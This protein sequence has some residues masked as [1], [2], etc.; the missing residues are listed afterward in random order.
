MRYTADLGLLQP[1]TNV[2]HAVWVDDEDL[3]LIA[4]SGATIA[5]NPV[6][7][8]RLGSGVMPWRAARD[9]GI[10]VA[11]GTDEAICDDTINLWT[12]AKVAALIHTVSGLDSDDWPAPAEVLDSLWLGGARAQRREGELGAVEVGMLADLALVDLRTIAFTPLN[13]LREQ[14]V[15]CEDGHDVVLTM[16][17]GRVVAE[18]GHVT[19][20]DETALL[21]E[22]RE[23]FAA[24]LPAV[25][26]AQAR[27]AET[28]FPAYQ[29]MVRRAA[30]TD[31]G[32][33]RWVGTRVTAPYAYSAMPSRPDGTWPNGARLAVVVC[34]GV[35]EY[36]FGDGHTEDVLP[37]VPAPDHVN[38][39][40]RDYGNRVGAFRLLDRLTDLRIRPTVLLNTDVYDTA[41]DVLVAARAAGAEFVGH[42]RSNSDSL[43]GMA[44]AEERA[45]LT[46]VAARIRAAEGRA[47][48]GWSSPWLAHTPATL[49]LLA[50]T[51]YEYLLDLRLDDQP[52]WLA[53]ASGPLLSIPYNAEI[54]DSSTM[55]GR[56]ASATEFAEM[57]VAEYEELAAAAADRP[58]VMSIVTAFVHQRRALPPARRRAGAREGGRRR[59]A[60]GSR[61]PARSM[62]RCSPIR[63][64]SGDRRRWRDDRGR[65]RRRRRRPVAVARAQR[66]SQRGA[67]A[68]RAWRSGPGR[69]WAWSANPAAARA[70]SRSA[71]SGCCPGA[72]NP[73]PTAQ[74]TVTGVDMLRARPEE[75]RRVRRDALGAIFQDPMT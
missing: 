67:A 42:G 69:S 14:L 75:L 71:C 63:R 20:V 28:L 50:E 41:P 33:T 65:A 62:P 52:V 59:R 4:A 22:A 45:Y 46:D 57:I 13:D 27:D 43:V 9:R 6:S 70:C 68:R 10:P 34:V 51:G 12:V 44:P 7:N 54:N 15:H 66:A 2:I 1:H 56:Q 39:A 72:R 18:H 73:R 17:D 29:R 64:P 61:R 58:L 31:V 49:D 47:P 35:E 11:L 26:A 16:V 25:R 53:T 23:L 21:D 38:T 36:R 60:C 48:G 55:I 19:A 32:F 37:G 24:K 5:H 40:W 30:A 3:D 74:C 8:L